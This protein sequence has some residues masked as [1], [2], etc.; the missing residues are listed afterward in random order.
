MDKIMIEIERL[1]KEIERI[2]EE[3][4]KNNDTINNLEKES[5][6]NQ[7]SLGDISYNIS[8][9][10][11]GEQNSK[12]LN[13]DISK[14]KGKIKICISILLGLIIILLSIHSIVEGVAILSIISSLSII[15]ATLGL[16]GNTKKFLTLKKRK[17]IYYSEDDLKQMSDKKKKLEL[18]KSDKLRQ[19]NINFNELERLKKINEDISKEKEIILNK[20][21][22]LQDLREKTIEEFIKNNTEFE[23]TMNQIY[24]A[25]YQKKLKY[26]NK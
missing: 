14:T 2:E 7:I 25:G 20:I 19:T 6:Y 3:V 4:K 13:Q 5:T 12:I 11:E 8:I 22:F 9:L 24:E 1:K 21:Y 17:K 16:F 18:E 15:G 23:N 10:S 26:K